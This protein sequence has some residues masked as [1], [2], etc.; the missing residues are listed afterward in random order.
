LQ[1]F[2]WNQ[3][4]SQDEREWNV[5]FQVIRNIVSNIP[6]VENS[7]KRLDDRWECNNNSINQNKLLELLKTHT[8]S[9][10]FGFKVVVTGPAPSQDSYERLRK[11]VDRYLCTG[12]QNEKLENTE[13]EK[14]SNENNEYKKNIIT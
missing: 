14:I 2:H 9:T 6:H 13:R 4:S 11:E 12:S 1:A 3:K 5:D 10:R 8:F 7:N